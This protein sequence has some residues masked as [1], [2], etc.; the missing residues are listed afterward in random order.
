MGAFQ[1]PAKEK[2]SFTSF[3]CQWISQSY[4]F[5]GFPLKILVIKEEQLIFINQD[6]RRLHNF[7][8]ALI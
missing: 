4:L 8:V 6:L 1:Q 5:S 7:T 2:Y 3:Y